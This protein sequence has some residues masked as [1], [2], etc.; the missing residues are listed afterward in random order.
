MI[1]DSLLKASGLLFAQ[2]LIVLLIQFIYIGLRYRYPNNNRFYEWVVIFTFLVITVIS[3]LI[4]TKVMP[5]SITSR[6]PD[7]Q[8]P[9]YI[10]AMYFIAFSAFSILKIEKFLFIIAPLELM[11]D[12]FMLRFT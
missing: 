8:F 6:N 4:N 10:Y 12:Y 1:K 7:T 5:K 2:H 9:D 11:S 3:V